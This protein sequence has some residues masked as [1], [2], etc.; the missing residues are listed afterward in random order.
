MWSLKREAF[1]QI[2]AVSAC[3][4]QMQRARYVRAVLEMKVGILFCVKIIFDL[5][6]NR[7][8]RKGREWGGAIRIHG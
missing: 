5:S 6:A 8:R 2:Q 4:M 7:L 1:K 3:A